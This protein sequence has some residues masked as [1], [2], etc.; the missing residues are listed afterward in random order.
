MEE[1][2]GFST[3]YYRFSERIK[4]IEGNLTRK[5][6][7]VAAL[8]GIFGVCYKNNKIK[9]ELNDIKKE[10]EAS[11]SLNSY[12]KDSL[13]EMINNILEKVKKESKKILIIIGILIVI[14]LIISGGNGSGGSSSGGS[15]SNSSSSSSG[16]KKGFY[17]S[18]GEYHAYI[19]EF[20]E[21]VNNWMENNW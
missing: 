5:I 2:K 15:S 6:S 18:Q 3:E 21:D 13:K 4:T 1:K 8:L 7:G 12:E 19:P 11:D 10:V 16:G 14:L 20:G 9:K 17:D